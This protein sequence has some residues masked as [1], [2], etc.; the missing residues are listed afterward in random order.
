MKINKKIST[1]GRATE[2]ADGFM[3]R[4]KTSFSI[5]IFCNFCKS[6]VEH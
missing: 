5:S 1:T 4:L 6:E 3:C 2:Q